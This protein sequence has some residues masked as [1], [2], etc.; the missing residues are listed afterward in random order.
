[1]ASQPE[2]LRKGSPS[3]D[4]GEALN[5]ARVDEAD[6]MSMYSVVEMW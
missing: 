1:M 4:A 3:W 6:P 2:V 5:E